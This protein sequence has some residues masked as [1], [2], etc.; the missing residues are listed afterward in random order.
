M[1]ERNNGSLLFRE[2]QYF[3]QPWI[4]LIVLG[5]FALF[6]YLIVQQLILGK[7]VGNNPASDT[8]LI[9]LVV[10]F[11]LGLP[12]LF[13]MTKLVVEVRDD[14]LYIRFFPFHFSFRKIPLED[15]KTCEARTYSPLKEYG[16]WGIR[17]GPKGKAYNVS[18]NRGVQLEPANGKRILIGS[19]KPEELAEAIGLVLKKQGRVR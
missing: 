2:T 10:I 17:Y 9:I 16:G 3:R 15:L 6:A 11:G 8:E 5:I 1:V 4:W 7:P 13:F 18:G 14:G 19:Q 12:L